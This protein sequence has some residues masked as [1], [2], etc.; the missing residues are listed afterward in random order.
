LARVLLYVVKSQ[1][2]GAGE[3]NAQTLHGG[4]AFYPLK[5]IV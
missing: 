3:K 1:L 2:P 5:A 4:F